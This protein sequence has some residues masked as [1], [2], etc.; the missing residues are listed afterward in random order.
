MDAMAR[1]V[2]EIRV[3]RLAAARGLQLVNVRTRKL[4]WRA[5]ELGP[6]YLVRDADSKF[7]LSP[8]VDPASWDELPLVPKRRETWMSL[9]EAEALIL[10]R[11]GRWRPRCTR[12]GV[13]AGLGGAPRALVR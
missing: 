5:R 8:G 4:S 7:Y 2:T 11:G 3:R 10:G 1:K 13:T 6:R 12:A 9:S